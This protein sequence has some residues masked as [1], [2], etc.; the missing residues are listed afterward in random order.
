[1][2]PSR[3]TSKAVPADARNL[4][5]DSS[6]IHS[7]VVFVDASATGGSFDELIRPL[8]ELSPHYD[9][10][11][12]EISRDDNRDARRI[13]RSDRDS[14]EPTEVVLTSDGYPVVLPT[15]R[16]SEAALARLVRDNPAAIG[17]LWAIDK[18]ARAGSNASGDRAYLRIIVV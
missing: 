17:E 18:S 15:L 4:V 13:R 8:R 1:M 16:E 5:E 9:L 7:G 14:D 12:L 10:D 2:G 11:A 6:G 3:V